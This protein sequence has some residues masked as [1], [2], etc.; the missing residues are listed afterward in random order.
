[1]LPRPYPYLC[2]DVL[3]VIPIDYVTHFQTS[4]VNPRTDA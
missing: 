3:R 2:V 1:M 4:S